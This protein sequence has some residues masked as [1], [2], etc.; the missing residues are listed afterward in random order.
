MVRWASLALTFAAAV[1][2]WRLPPSPPLLDR[3][4]DPIFQAAASERQGLMLTSGSF[5]LVQLYTRRPVLIDSGALDT[6]M[7]APEGGPGME[8]ILRDAYDIDFF[9]PP[10]DVRRSAW[11]PHSFNQPTWQGFSRERWRE[12]GSRFDVT[13][14]LTRASYVLDLPVVAEDARFKLYRIPRDQEQGARH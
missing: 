9:N 4:N 11:I 12:I 3:T 6:L 10:P 5:H 14:V 2:L 8:R 13:Q 1:L 7:Y